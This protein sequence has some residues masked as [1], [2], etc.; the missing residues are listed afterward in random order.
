MTKRNRGAAALTVPIVLLLAGV[1]VLAFP[2]ITR[3]QDR[4][5]DPR[6]QGAEGPSVCGLVAV[7]PRGRWDPLEKSRETAVD[8]ASLAIEQ[9]TQ[10]SL[11]TGDALISAV[12]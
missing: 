7:E 3:A 4:A 10:A 11:L 1:G 12:L 2:L 5:A 9:R 8:W 6:G